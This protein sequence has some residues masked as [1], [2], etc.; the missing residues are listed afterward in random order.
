MKK[1][2]HSRAESI[3]QNPNLRSTNF[4]QNVYTAKPMEIPVTEF[5][6]RPQSYVKKR[7]KLRTPSKDRISQT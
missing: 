2:F 3:A 6:I 5:K 4:K 7:M 1:L